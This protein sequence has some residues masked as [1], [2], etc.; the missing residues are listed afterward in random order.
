MSVDVIAFAVFAA[1]IVERLFELVVS[2]RNARWSLAQG[3]VEYGGDHFKWMVVLHTLFLLSIIGEYV[4]WG[5]QIAAGYRLLAVSVA[6]VCQILRWWIIH[7]LGKQWNTRVIVV[8]GLTRVTTG[9][10][11]YMNHPNY[12]VVAIETLT[13]PLILG[14]WRTSILFSILNV[15]MMRVRI[16]VENEA[17]R[18]LR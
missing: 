13:L 9:P 11:R 2:R 1:T 12:V 16:R 14:S 4:V 6:L 18:G 10:Y 17:L 3:G 5:P 7:T 15:L 8:P